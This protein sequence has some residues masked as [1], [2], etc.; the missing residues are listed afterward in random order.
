[1]GVIHVL[2][3]NH[4]LMAEEPLT[5]AEEEDLEVEAEFYFKANVGTAESKVIWNETV[6]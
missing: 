5:L 4:Q 3:A 2:I 6:G 1:M